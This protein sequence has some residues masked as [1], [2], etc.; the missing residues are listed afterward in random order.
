METVQQMPEQGQQTFAVLFESYPQ[1]RIYQLRYAQ[2]MLA[3][4]LTRQAQVQLE[5]TLN[6][7]TN[8]GDS[9]LQQYI[10]QLLAQVQLN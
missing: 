4:G 9:E 5:H 3:A 1:Q 8:A 7:A 6:L 10:S 2:A